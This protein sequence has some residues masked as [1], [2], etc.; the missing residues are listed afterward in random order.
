MGHPNEDLVRAG[1]AA[2]GAGDIESLRETYFDPGIVWHFPGNNPFSGDFE[3]IDA[4][5]GWLG[6][7][8]EASGGTISIELHDVLANDEHAVALAHVTA[9]RNGKSLDDSGVQLFHVSNGKVTEVWTY[10]ADQAASDAFW[11]D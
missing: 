4:V 9:Q 7:S 3:G 8:F 11:S 6:R 1:Y 5:I 10:S 2:F